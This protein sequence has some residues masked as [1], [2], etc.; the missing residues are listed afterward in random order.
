MSSGFIL[1]PR[2][3]DSTDDESDSDAGSAGEPRE[4]ERDRM[5]ADRMLAGVAHGSFSDTDDEGDHDDDDPVANMDTTAHP[6]A[7]L[8]MGTVHRNDQ[9]APTVR[10]PESS[11]PL[12]GSL[13]LST[14]PLTSAA[15]VESTL[16]GEGVIADAIVEGSDAGTAV[17]VDVTDVA[18]NASAGDSKRPQI[19]W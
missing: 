7:P 9:H 12:P 6:V 4:L 14:S 1:P 16:R 5:P 13:S 10:M 15:G 19:T 8:G 2:D 18:L 17:V 3:E 11:S